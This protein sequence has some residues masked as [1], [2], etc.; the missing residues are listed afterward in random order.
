MHIHII[1][2]LSKT[3]YVFNIDAHI[4]LIGS[5]AS[6]TA[7]C[8]NLLPRVAQN[9]IPT[10]WSRRATV[11]WLG[12]INMHI[13]ITSILSKTLYMCLTLMGTQ[14]WF[15]IQPQWLHFAFSCCRELPSILFDSWSRR[16]TVMWFG[17]IHMHIHIIWRLSKTLYVFD[18]DMWKQSW[19]CLW[20]QSWHFAI[21][22]C[23][24][25][26]QN[27]DKFQKLAELEQP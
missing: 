18:I 25:V 5:T 14:S 11:M 16:A 27:L 7:L 20:P 17:H 8:N 22:C 12:H 3:L 6:I 9:P 1:W 15:G 26:T 23:W 4:I 19:L 10:A 24:G 2:R 13:Q 21:I